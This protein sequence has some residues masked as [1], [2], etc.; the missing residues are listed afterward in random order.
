M[1]NTQPWGKEMDFNI[2]HV[3]DG[4]GPAIELQDASKRDEHSIVADARFIDPAG[5]DY[6]VKK[7]SPAL[8]LGFQN[9][10]MDQFGVISPKL[11]AEAKTPILPGSEPALGIR[12][13][14]PKRANT[15]HMWLGATIMNVV[16]MG[17]VSSRGLP[18]ETGVMLVDVPAASAAGECGLRNSDAILT[19][20]GKRVETVEDL[21]RLYRSATPGSTIKLG[22]FREQTDVTVEIVRGYEIELHAGD[23]T[24]HGTSGRYDP[25]KKFLGSW[26]KED[27]WLEWNATV[28]K[29]GTYEAEI[30]QA[31]P[32]D[33]A[34]SEYTIN[35]GKATIAG[36]VEATGGWEDFA[37]KTV[38]TI[39]LTESGELKVSLKP[40][41]KASQA[42]MNI[43]AIVLKPR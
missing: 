26:T 3:P 22:V 9:F 4:T 5:G 24:K 28:A 8:E 41:K 2:L 33:Q 30:V 31:C 27:T 1:S 40:T 15:I 21:L 39:D 6:R 38:G 37:T 12:R 25:N 11:K 17:E 14:K 23:A 42:V 32:S 13:D 19:C 35:V 7:G 36:Q 10:A 16:G 34:G 43:R 29:P 20:L 18:S